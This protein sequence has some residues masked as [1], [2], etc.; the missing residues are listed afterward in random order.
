MHRRNNITMK[1][2]IKSFNVS[3]NDL[4]ALTAVRN[5]SIAGDVGSVFS[6]EIKN[7][8][9]KYYS[10]DTKAFSTSTKISTTATSVGST[11]NSREIVLL[12]GNTSIKVGMNIVGD[13]IDEQTK[14]VALKAIGGQSSD[15]HSNIV[16]MD[17][18]HSILGA[19]ALTMFFETGLND[20]EMTST[21]YSNK[22]TFPTVTGD[23]SYT[24]ALTANHR[25]ETFLQEIEAEL[26]LDSTSDTFGD[27]LTDGFRNNLQKVITVY[28][29]LDTVVTINMV[30][31]SLTALD[32]NFSANTF[33]ISR[34]RGFVSKN[35]N[36]SKTSFSFTFTTPDSSAITK[37]KDPIVN[38]FETLETQTVNGVIS[39]SRVVTLDSVDNLLVGMKVT[40][41]SSGSIVANTFIASINTIQKTITITV[42][43]SFADGITLTFTAFGNTGSIAYGSQIAIENLTITLTPLIVTVAAASTDAT[44][45]LDSAVGIKGTSTTK[46]TGIGIPE[47]TTISARSSDVITLSSGNT[48]L[49]AGTILTVD[50]SSSSATVTGDVVLRQMG[51]KDFTTS[52]NIDSFAAFGIS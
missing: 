28:Q 36:S 35:I 50:G 2:L 32:V 39:N 47:N 12:G 5:F 46:V 40:G 45:E 27:F 26:N 38:H 44:P 24:I 42:N 13:G 23:D 18:P 48:V 37:S 33:N 20:V 21:L 3:S 16:I 17:K 6:L 52:L 8:A 22:I 9:G 29:Y 10:F 31:A 19:T 4:Q 51:S 7:S 43:N 25:H 49:E 15:A 11:K 34:P 1:K 30:S 41:V 14:V